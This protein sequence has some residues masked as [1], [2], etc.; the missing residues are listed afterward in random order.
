MRAGLLAIGVVFLVL[1]AMIWVFNPNP[2]CRNVAAV[3]AHC[4]APPES[5]NWQTGGS[6]AMTVGGILIVLGIVLNDDPREEPKVKKSRRGQAAMEFLMTYGWAILVVLA[7][8]AALAYFGVLP[9]FKDITHSITDGEKGRAWC[10]EYNMTVDAFNPSY[11]YK[12]IEHC[13]TN[14]AN[15]SRCTTEKWHCRIPDIG[16]T[17]ISME[18]TTTGGRT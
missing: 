14:R 3:P 8:V 1:G 7:A 4:L 6:W 9:G 5:N 15:I 16:Q 13:S 2:D 18:C 17:L 10:E 12:S 11:C